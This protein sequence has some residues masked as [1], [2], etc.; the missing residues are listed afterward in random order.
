MQIYFYTNKQF[1]LE[2]F[3]LSWVDSLIVKNISISIYS[4]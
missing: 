2:Q 1:Y 4:V 3:C